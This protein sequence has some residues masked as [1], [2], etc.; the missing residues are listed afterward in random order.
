[1]TPL[2]LK[3]SGIFSYQ[4]QCLIDFEKLSAQG[5]FGIFGA[6]G[7]GKSAII[8]A[9]T[10]ALYGDYHRAPGKDIY[11][12][13]MNLKSNESLIEFRFSHKEQIYEF[14]Y[15]AKRS[16]KSFENIT[17]QYRKAYKW[18]DN[19]L[20]PL[21]SANAAHILDL[22]FDEF[23]KLV[24]IPQGQFAE[25]INLSDGNRTKMLKK[26]LKLDKYALY[27]PTNQLFNDSKEKLAFID[28]QLSA[29]TDIHED[30]LET[31][32]SNLL[33]IDEEIS[34]KNHKINDLRTTIEAQKKYQ[35]IKNELDQLNKEWGKCIEKDTEIAQIEQ[36]LQQHILITTQFQ[37]LHI[38]KEQFEANHSQLEEKLKLTT[39]ASIDNQKKCNDINTTIKTKLNGCE[40]IEE[41]KE[42]IDKSIH[43]NNL[44]NS[45]KEL[46]NSKVLLNQ[47]KQQLNKLEKSKSEYHNSLQTVNLKLAQIH[48]YELEE[49]KLR[50]TLHNYKIFEKNNLEINELLS[51]I[52]LTEDEIS[53]FGDK[54]I[55]YLEVNNQYLDEPIPTD[56]KITDAILLLE[57][58]IRKTEQEILKLESE[59]SELLNNH[60]LNHFALNL[61]P[62]IPCPLCGATDHPSIYNNS[63][64][65]ILVNDKK[66]EI[67][68]KNKSIKHITKTINELQSL[69]ELFKSKSNDKARLSDKL[70]QIKAEN[71]QLISTIGSENIDEVNTKLDRILALKIEKAALIKTKETYEKEI[72]RIEQSIAN[73]N[74]TALEHKLL[75]EESTIQALKDTYDFENQKAVL[76]EKEILIAK[77]SLSYI[78]QMQATLQSIEKE[79]VQLFATLENLNKELKIKEIEKLKIIKNWNEQ[80]EKYNLEENLVIDHLTKE[81]GTELIREQIQNHKSKKSNIENSINRLKD[82]IKDYKYD[83][84]QLEE[85]IQQLSTL[86]Q[87][88]QN[89]ITYKELLKAEITQIIEKSIAKKNLLQEHEQLSNRIS[90]LQL[91]LSM[92]RGDKFVQYMSKQ[93]TQHLFALANIRFKKLTMNQ[94]ELSIDQDN[95]FAIIDYMNDKRPRSIKTLSGGQLFQASLCLALALSEQIQI[96]HGEKQQ[97]FFIDE[98]FGT[99]DKDNLEIVLETLRA[100]KKEGRTVGIISHVDELRENI[101]YHLNI[102]RDPHIGS[103]I[104]EVY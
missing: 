37:K 85:N 17:K 1:M 68:N 67:Q 64:A 3:F 42:L 24:I 54:K 39:L 5:I 88:L 90:N 33:N 74:I 30:Q 9:M 31:K 8:D 7:S 59:I 99:L 97:F 66:L 82:Q 32:Q 28:G 44:Q 65:S 70:S 60:A 26:I 40:N 23:T 35:D 41:L 62:G 15:Y 14:H 101:D 29:L 46:D 96:L 25:F 76:T 81:L 89:S 94:L 34:N 63:H 93:Y 18:E 53:Q 45:I 38:I 11:Y 77:E 58:I 55:S 51:L 61:Q 48:E 100:L 98:G 103:R 43:Y 22:N 87:E 10:F 73:L 57:A 72:S 71:E 52:K 20:I 4:K 83:L 84:S 21:P 102:T 91:L 95:N 19:Q 75:K 80:L 16:S 27:H 56:T 47:A 13:L 12:N 104:E 86:T 69:I 49:I 6:V 78:A 36:E 50:D 92:F 79:G 2:L